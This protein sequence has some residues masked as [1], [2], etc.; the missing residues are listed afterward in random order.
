ME[1]KNEFYKCEICGNVLK[2]VEDGGAVPVCCGQ[3][4]TRCS[5]KNCK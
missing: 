4:M 5:D 1:K 2:I 3:E